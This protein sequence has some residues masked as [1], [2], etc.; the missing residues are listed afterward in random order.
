[1]HQTSNSNRA[2]SFEV[3]KKLR[4]PMYIKFMDKNTSVRDVGQRSIEL[5]CIDPIEVGR[6]LKGTTTLIPVRG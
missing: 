3:E 2:L 4:S 1:M 5:S 6:V